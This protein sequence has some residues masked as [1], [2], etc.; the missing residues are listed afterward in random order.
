MQH[1]ILTII[2]DN[3]NKNKSGFNNNI[4]TKKNNK[5]LRKVLNISIIK[6]IN[7]KKVTF[8]LYKKNKKIKNLN[9]NFTK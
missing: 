4:S 5:I 8:S 6:N 9:V 1:N 2:N 3:L 7:S